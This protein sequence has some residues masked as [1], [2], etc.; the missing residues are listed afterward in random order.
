VKAA[1][2]G[3]PEV[4]PGGWPQGSSRLETPPPG[5]TLAGTGP[6]WAGGGRQPWPALGAVRTRG[7][8]CWHPLSSVGCQKAF[9]RAFGAWGGP[10]G[11]LSGGHQGVPTGGLQSVPRGAEAVGGGRDGAL[12]GAV[13][14]ALED[15]RYQALE[16]QR[17]NQ[18]IGLPDRALQAMKGSLEYKAS[19]DLRQV[20]LTIHSGS[21]VVTRADSALNKDLEWKTATVVLTSPS[22]SVTPSPSPAPKRQAS[23]VPRH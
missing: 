3:Q 17:A 9:W 18:P 4:Y 22:A 23:P 19:D 20:T 16:A 2:L 13:Q 1:V 8:G 15:G 21:W 5:K 7:A 10:F 14:R 12:L 6:A 11:A